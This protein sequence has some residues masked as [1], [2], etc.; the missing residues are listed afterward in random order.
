VDLHRPLFSDRATDFYEL[1]DN[2]EE[3]SKKLARR[4]ND[5][6]RSIL[7][8]GGME[9]VFELASK[10]ESPMHV[11]AALGVI[12]GRDIDKFLLPGF[13][14]DESRSLE[15]LIGGYIWSRHREQGWAWVDGLGMSQWTAAQ[16]VRLLVRLPFC[17]G[18]WERAEALLGSGEADYWS[19]VVATPYGIE[20]ELREAAVKLLHHGRPNSAIDC[21]Y[22]YYRE[23]HALDYGLVTEALL[24]ATSTTEPSSSMRVYHAIELIKALQDEP[25]TDLKSICNVE[26]AYLS[27]L[28]DHRQATPRSLERLL[29]SD[30]NFF[31][32]VIRH[33]FR[34][35]NE[36]ATQKEP[37]EQEKQFARNAFRL[38]HKWKVPPGDMPEG[39]F[40][41]D[42]FRV[43]L[44]SVK[45]ACKESGHL[46]VAQTQI[47]QVLTHVPPDEDGLWINKAVAEAL[48]AS[49]AEDMRRGFCIGYY[50]IRGF[51]AVDPTGAPEK[52]LA[53][54]FRQRADD[55]ERCGYHRLA[56]SLRQLADS[57]ICEDERIVEEHRARTMQ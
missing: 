17:R 12:A 50:N 39:G 7:A 31:C 43:W 4:R 52:E 42:R 37:T 46:E 57:Y 51:H 11:G 54:K 14:I 34:S 9:S 23:K 24:A 22:G 47:G 56:D 25:G 49:D 19:K 21:L 44:E 48:N 20:G 16:V 30:P 13:L 38:L 41:G 5:A 2:W 1:E 8:S 33:I 3:Q 26:W 32:D 28:D 6:V 29:S 55:V 53:A 18:T 15:Q 27:V 35:K 45:S 10:A 40:S 36:T